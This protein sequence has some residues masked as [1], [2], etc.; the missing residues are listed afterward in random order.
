[1]PQVILVQAD[2]EL[3]TLKDLV[4]LARSKGDN[5][6][7]GSAGIGASNHL[8]GEMLNA[9]AGIS[10]MHVPYKG[11]SPSISDV[12][13]GRID[14]VLPTVVAGIP[15]VRGG[16]LKALAVTSNKR[17]ESLPDVPTVNEA[18]EID[19][20]EAVSWGGFMV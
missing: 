6:T 18:L 8:S 19:T 2:S 12:I 17:V 10:M 20:F 9:T 1:V 11:D 4:E 13:G 7:Y 3:N 14:V 16:K 5:V 15:H